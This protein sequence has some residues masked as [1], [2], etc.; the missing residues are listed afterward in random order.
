VHLRNAGKECVFPPADVS[1]KGMA[2]ALLP[3]SLEA[4]ATGPIEVGLPADE[5][6][7]KLSRRLHARTSAERYATS[8]VAV[9]DPVRHVLRYANAGHN[10]ALLVRASGE[11]LRLAAT[12][13]PLGG[14]PLATYTAEEVALGAGDSLV[15]YTDGIT[16]AANPEG[17]EYGIERLEEVVRRHRTQPLETF[18]GALDQDVEA[19]TRG[20]PFGDDRT[21]IVVRRES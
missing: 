8:F 10:P 20:V 9:L 18:L 17:E 7:E 11:S 19:F 12:G 2:A 15:A 3:A 16:E 5:I 14:L 1:G 6:S 13:I 21:L 4:L